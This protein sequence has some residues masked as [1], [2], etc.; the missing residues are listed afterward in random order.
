MFC[1]EALNSVEAIAA[2]ELTPEGRI[3]EHLTTCAD[4]AAALESARRVER[5]L[6]ARPAPSAPAQFT[7]RTLGRVRRAR[8]RSEQVVDAGFNAAIALIVAGV[9][10]G[11]WMLAHRTGL[12]AV[13]N[14]AVELFA[15]GLS[16]F[17]RRVGPSLPLYA[18]A[19]ALVGTALG[20]WWWAERDMQA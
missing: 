19:T 10:V 3:A 16:A 1:D 7:T 20:I 18:G 9:V 2:G 14:D 4:C 5:L 6:R 15:T 11:I 12:A 13:S 8:W 17:A